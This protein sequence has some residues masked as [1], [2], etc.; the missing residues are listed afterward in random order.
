MTLDELTQKEE[1]LNN[2]ASELLRTAQDRHGSEK[3]ERTLRDETEMVS[4]KLLWEEV[5]LNAKD[6]TAVDILKKLH[7]AVFKAY[8]DQ[9]KAAD[10]LQRFIVENMGFDFRRMKISDYIKLCEAV[11]DMKQRERNK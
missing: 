7:P 6:G 4:Q 2:I 3:V 5:F 10:E 1:Q 8:E 9:G 11:F